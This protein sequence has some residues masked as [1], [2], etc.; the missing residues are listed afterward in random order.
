MLR[1]IIS[2][3]FLFITAT[4]FAQ[5]TDTIVVQKA[6]TLQQS[7]PID[8]CKNRRVSPIHTLGQVTVI[9]TLATGNSAISILLFNDNTWRY[10]LDESFRNDTTIYN[11]QDRK[12]VV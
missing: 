8:S 2:T 1:Y 11:D 5:D 10:L 4:V 3:I 7:T 12:S 9:D 6:D